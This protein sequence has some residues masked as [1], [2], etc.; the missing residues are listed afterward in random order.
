MCT[1]GR[2]KNDNNT[3]IE[4]EKQEQ[5]RTIQGRPILCIV[6]H[7]NET[8]HSVI[9]RTLVELFHFRSNDT[10]SL[11]MDRRHLDVNR[12]RS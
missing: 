10:F 12:Q 1:I 6:G 11:I 9:D 2:C 3:R 8:R 5:V 4:K 7:V